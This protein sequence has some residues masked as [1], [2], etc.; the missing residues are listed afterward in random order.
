M[1]RRGKRPAPSSGPASSKTSV[2]DP[3]LAEALAAG[4]LFRPLPP[5]KRHELNKMVETLL[6]LSSNFGQDP[7]STPQGLYEEHLQLSALLKN[8]V[9]LE[10]CN[11]N[12]KLLGSRV[13]HAGAMIKWVEEHGGSVQGVKPHNFGERGVSHCNNETWSK[14]DLK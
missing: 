14:M 1:G 4:G 2:T 7:P 5:N 12:R 9:E 6:H 11:L 8:I 3:V 10:K 13:G